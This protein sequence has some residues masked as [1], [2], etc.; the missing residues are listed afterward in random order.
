MSTQKIFSSKPA[1]IAHAAIKLSTQIFGE[2]K[3][4]KIAAIGDKELVFSITNNFKKYVKLVD[5][6]FLQKK[7]S[8]KIV[9]ILILTLSY[10][11]KSC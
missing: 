5:L 10:T 8:Q 7:I 4:I 11:S 3:K 6:I 9:F 2:D 1:Q